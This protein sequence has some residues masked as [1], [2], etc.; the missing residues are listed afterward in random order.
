MCQKF[1]SGL[2]LKCEM[3]CHQKGFNGKVLIFL[4]EKKNCLVEEFAFQ[5]YTGRLDKLK[6]CANN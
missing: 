3:E 6:T 4:N 2:T 1:L 5:N